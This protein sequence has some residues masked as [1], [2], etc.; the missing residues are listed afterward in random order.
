MWTAITGKMVAV[1][2]SI[3]LFVESAI[4]L[5]PFSPIPNTARQ[6]KCTKGC[7]AVTQ[8]MST[9]WTLVTCAVIT[10]IAHRT[11]WTIWWPMAR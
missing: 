3:L 6:T 7:K 4:L 5:A 8:A 9:C 1:S 2:P 11:R 10:R